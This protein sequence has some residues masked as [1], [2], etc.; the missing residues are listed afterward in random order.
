VARSTRSTPRRSRRRR[1][2]MSLPRLN[3]KAISPDVGRSIVGIILLVAGAVTLIA[4]ALPGQGRLTDWWRDTVVPFFGAGRW[5]LP[6]LLIAAGWYVEWGPGKQRNSGWGLTLVG[7]SV[8]Y[9]A[10]LGAIETI[11]IAAGG[12]IG[13]FLESILTPLLTTP[14]AVVVLAGIAIGGLLVGFNLQLKE[15]L[16]PVT[17]TARWFGNTAAASMRR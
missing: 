6:F 13:R 15:L 14:G 7:A 3:L 17:G 12:R 9:A 11:H 2:A 1:S 16:R 8:S 5:V 10:L 4:L